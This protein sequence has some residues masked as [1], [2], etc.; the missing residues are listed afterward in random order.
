MAGAEAAFHDAAMCAQSGGD[1]ATALL[2][3][4]W[5]ATLYGRQGRL[6]DKLRTCSQ[7]I[8]SGEMVQDAPLPVLG[9]AWIRSGEVW[10]ERND[11]QQAEV[12]IT[13]GLR[14]LSGAIEQLIL[15]KG[16]VVRARIHQARG[17]PDAALATI[18]EAE[19]WA[20]R[21]QLDNWRFQGL[22]TA[23]R[24]RLWLRQG[25]F[26]AAFKWAD[27]VG[28]GNE[29][30]LNDVLHL[31][32]IQVRLAQ[33]RD[34]PDR[35]RL[36]QLVGMVARLSELVENLDWVHYRIELLLLQSMIVHVQGNLGAALNLLASALRLAAPEGYERIFLDE[37]AP[38]AALLTTALQRS[39]WGT[40]EHAHAHDVRRYSQHLLAAF[41]AEGITAARTPLALRTSD[42]DSLTERELEVLHLLTEGLSN[43]AI[44]EQ[45]VV[46][47][48][49]VKRHV[50]SILSKLAVQSRLQA[51]A[52][53][54]ELN[55]V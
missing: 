4:G 15:A 7:I 48:G 21:L 39:E 46:A 34:Q 41:E 55:L 22:L 42:V 24:V 17:N 14:L 16:Y 54:R 35:S 27:T 3:S 37:G 10:Y 44:A 5:L 23:C 11:L 29:L 30:H 2:A 52:R 36:D 8:T 50:N 51:V 43:Q 26:D 33:Y 20:A 19:A 45:L 53:A 28:L 40:A 49:T 1:P 38:L 13:E 18:K 31:T 9:A 47:V 25:N 32:L 12:A 6:N